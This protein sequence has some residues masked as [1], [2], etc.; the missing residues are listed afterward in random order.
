MFLWETSMF[1]GMRTD[2]LESQVKKTFLKGFL[3]RQNSFQGKKKTST[4]GKEDLQGRQYGF[5]G[6]I[7]THSGETN[8]VAGEEE[9]FPGEGRK[10][11]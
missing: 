8:N 9:M 4:N 11:P 2:F 1:P 10:L 5:P 7:Q 6:E 3:G